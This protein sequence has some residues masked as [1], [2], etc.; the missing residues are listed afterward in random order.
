ML[1]QSDHKG[2]REVRFCL[3]GLEGLEMEER[4][5]SDLHF[6]GTAV[7][8]GVP[9]WVRPGTQPPARCCEVVREEVAV[10]ARTWHPCHLAPRL[11]SGDG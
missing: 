2:S 8:A 10:A 11:S 7:G 6:Q 3:E 1:A 4:A 9:R 5:P